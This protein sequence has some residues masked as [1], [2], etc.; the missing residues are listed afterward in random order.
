[1]ER[2][3]GRPVAEIQGDRVGAARAFAAEHGVGVVLKGA[4]SVI[5]NPAGEGSGHA[6]A[7]LNPTGNTGLSKGGSG[8]VLTGLIGGLVAQGLAPRDAAICGVHWHGLAADLVAQ[9]IPE[10]AM[11]PDDVVAALGPALRQILE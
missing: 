4:Q 8:D 1:M 10:Q 3:S 2:L 11:T 7:W 9:T 6:E 5:A